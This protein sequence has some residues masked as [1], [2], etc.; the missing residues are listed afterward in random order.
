MLASVLIDYVA[1]SMMGGR[2][3][4]EETWLDPKL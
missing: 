1:A 4:F 3:L 2:G